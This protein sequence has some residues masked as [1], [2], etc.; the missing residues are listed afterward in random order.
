MK[1]LI[2]GEAQSWALPEIK[3]GSYPRAQIKF[4][5]NSNLASSL[6]FD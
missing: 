5:A 2:A 3:E 6:T 1:F 4:E